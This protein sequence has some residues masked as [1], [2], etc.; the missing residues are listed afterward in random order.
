[1]RKKKIA[2]EYESYSSIRDHKLTEVLRLSNVKVLVS[3]WIPFGRN[4]MVRSWFAP[5][6]CLLPLWCVSRIA[7]KWKVRDRGRW[8]RRRRDVEHAEGQ[9][10]RDDVLLGARAT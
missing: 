4:H 9:G 1:M 8:G 5:R 2:G 10:H 3:E 7:W 6:L